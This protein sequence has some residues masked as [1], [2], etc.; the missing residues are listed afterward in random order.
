LPY[1]RN[2]VVEK[3][4]GKYAQE[5]IDKYLES[6]GYGAYKMKDTFSTQLKVNQHFL[7]GI[8][9]EDLNDKD[10]HIRDG[11]FELISNVLFHSTGENQ[12]HPRIAFHFTTPMRFG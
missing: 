6:T 1:I 10:R 2:H 5:V 12:W 9:E 4:F 7:K 11:L 3:I 8:E